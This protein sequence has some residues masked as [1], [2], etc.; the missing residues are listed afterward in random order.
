MI[1]DRWWIVTVTTEAPWDAELLPSALLEAGARAVV[2]EDEGRFTAPFEPPSD[3][4]AEAT[5]LSDRLAEETGLQDLVVT[6]RWQPHEDWEAL[7]RRGIEPRLVSPRIM[8]APSWDVPPREE[9]VVVVV[10][11]PGMAFGTAEHPTTRGC[12]RLL[13][14]LATPG[15]RIADIGS[16][17][18][19]LAVA[20]ALLGADQVLALESDPWAVEAARANVVR[21]GVEGRVQVEEALVDLPLLATLG[22]FDGILANIERGIVVPLLPGLV[23]ALRPGGWLILSGI[24]RGEAHLVEEAA[25]RVGLHPDG[26]EPEEEWWS[27]SFRLQEA[28]APGS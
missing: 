9:G 24:P 27:G 11:D 10:L 20:A 15:G 17:S 14:A 26:R 28:P 18:G 2:E 7:W 23:E 22:T 19:I 25:A 13:D 21:N 6:W 16:G 4:E 3:P 5:S 1:P 12:L 8:V